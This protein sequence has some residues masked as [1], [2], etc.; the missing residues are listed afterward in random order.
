[1]FID[2]GEEYWRESYWRNPSAVVLRHPGITPNNPA[3]AEGEDSEEFETVEL[4]E[5]A[6]ENLPNDI[7]EAKTKKWTQPKPKK[8]GVKVFRVAKIMAESFARHSLSKVTRGEEE[9]NCEED[10]NERILKLQKSYETRVV[11]GRRT[12]I[13]SDRQREQMSQLNAQMRRIKQAKTKKGVKADNPTLKE[14]MLRN[15]WPKFKMAIDEELNQIAVGEKAHEAKVTLPH[16]PPKG[17]NVIG[18]ML[19]LTVKR[20]PDGTIDKYKARLVA[21]GNHQKASSYEQVKPSTVR[22]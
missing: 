8:Y 10:I 19:V 6:P 21:F 3:P 4:P 22:G 13:V 5:G 7:Y 11:G 16:D 2:Y 18:S 15:D 9:R 12:T 14:A 20:R 17:S 1:M